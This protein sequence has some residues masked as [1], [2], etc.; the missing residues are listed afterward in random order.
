MDKYI[1]LQGFENTHNGNQIKHSG[2]HILNLNVL[3]YKIPLIFIE[4]EID[5]PVNIRE[6][7]HIFTEMDDFVLFLKKYTC[8][9]TQIEYE[10]LD[11]LI[12][13]YDNIELY[14]K[15]YNLDMNCFICGYDL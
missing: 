6:N 4:Y 8:D 3:F 10:N 13:F 7:T 5:E 11:D 1:N 2:Y 9:E 12:N 15:K 14:F